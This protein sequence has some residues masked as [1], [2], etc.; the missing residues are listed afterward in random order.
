MLSDNVSLVLIIR[1]LPG[2]FIALNIQQLLIAHDAPVEIPG[3][4]GKCWNAIA[5]W[6]TVSDPLCGNFTRNIV[7][8]LMNVSKASFHKSVDPE[9]PSPDS[10]F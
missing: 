9:I 4:V 6:T 3:K 8:L 5:H 1:V 10:P 2:H 7:V